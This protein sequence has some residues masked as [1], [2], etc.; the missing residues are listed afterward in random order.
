MFADGVFSSE[1]VLEFA[2]DVLC[3][4]KQCK[5]NALKNWMLGKLN[6]QSSPA[7]SEEKKKNLW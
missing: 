6:V 7:L 4:V 3:F 5:E 1:Y 2:I